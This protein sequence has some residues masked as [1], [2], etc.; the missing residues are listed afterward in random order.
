MDE[1]IP[2]KEVM[3]DKSEILLDKQVVVGNPVRVSESDKPDFVGFDDKSFDEELQSDLLNIPD[4]MLFKIGEVASLAGIKPYILRYWE[5]EFSSLR[6]KKASNNQRMY[7]RKDLEI[8][9]LIKKLL[10]RDRYSI[11]GAKKVLGGMK[12]EL[13]SFNKWL[14]VMKTQAD[15]SEKLQQL[16]DS[17]QD[18]KV[19]HSIV[20]V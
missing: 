20:Q 5:T 10:Y 6:P 14:K 2:E 17:I 3:I 12:L 9:F 13:K 18:A 4:K 8:V 15:A 11:Q 19:R 16:L 1:I 7:N